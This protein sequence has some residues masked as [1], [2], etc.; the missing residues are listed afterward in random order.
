MTSHVLNEVIFALSLSSLTLTAES[1]TF[2]FS[3]MFW[4]SGLW[5]LVESLRN[6]CLRIVTDQ[7]YTPEYFLHIVR[8]YKITHVVAGR[9]NMSE[10]VLYDNFN[11]IQKSLESIDTLI[12]AGAKAPLIIRE[13]LNSYL[14]CNTNRPGYSASYGMSEAGMI[15]T[16]SAYFGEYLEDS[17]GKLAANTMVRIINKEGERMGP[18]EQG[19]ICIYKPYTWLGYYNNEQATLKAK[20]DN[21]LFT[22]DIGY[23]DD[24]GF[25]HVCARDSDIFKSNGFQIHP[26]RLEDIIARLPGVLETCV[27]GIPDFA[28]VYLTACVVV[29]APN[30]Q[31]QKLTTKDID[32]QIK[33]NI[34]SMYNLNGGVYFMDDIPKTA[35]GKVQRRKVL[36][37]VMKLKE[38]K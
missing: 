35:S 5:T 24:Q 27:F 28:A 29:R 34:G 3:T 4:A 15:S 8:Q 2:T 14:A 11:K 36:E 18:N 21:W 19:E 23:F 31:G 17:E 10:L 33:A 30:E 37:L 22:G 9:P 12:V 25:M 16:N 1:V 6:A 13:K 32:Q 20:R 38:A 7:P 26:Q